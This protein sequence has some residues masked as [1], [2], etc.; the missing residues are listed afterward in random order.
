MRLFE[1]ILIVIAGQLALALAVIGGRGPRWTN[2]LPLVLLAPLAAH[3]AIEVARW[4]MAPAYFVVFVFCL[5]GAVRY[6]RVPL[7]GG[8]AGNA[9]SRRGGTLAR[10]A[11]AVMGIVGF[12]LLMVS[13]AAVVFSGSMG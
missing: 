6:L 12:L 2:L 8:S 4:Q 10:V 5:G 11:P 3:L 9:G 7:T 1:A 13:A